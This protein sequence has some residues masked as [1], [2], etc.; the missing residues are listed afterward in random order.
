MRE[1]G[2]ASG[3]DKGRGQDGDKTRT[4]ARPH[5]SFNVTFDVTFNV[6]CT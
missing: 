6:T 1:D 3:M 2:D 5:E 4:D